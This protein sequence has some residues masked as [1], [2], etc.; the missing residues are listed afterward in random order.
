MEILQIFGSHDQK[1]DSKFV[2]HKSRTLNSFS[3]TQP[4]FTCSEYLVLVSFEQILRIV[5]VLLLL[6]LNK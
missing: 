5:L 1:I 2:F 4:A 6:T 3:E